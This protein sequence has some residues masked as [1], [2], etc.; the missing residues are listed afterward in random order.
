MLC[1]QKD[2]KRNGELTENIH[3]C[4]TVQ[5]SNPFLTFKTPHPPPI[6]NFKRLIPTIKNS[7]QKPPTYPIKI[8]AATYPLIHSNLKSTGCPGPGNHELC[9]PSHHPI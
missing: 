3:L 6:Y 2:T 9:H 5:T 8:T 1:I 7:T 4:L